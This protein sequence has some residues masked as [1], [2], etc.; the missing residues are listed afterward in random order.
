MKNFAVVDLVEQDGAF[1]QQ[2]R[3]GL[4]ETKHKGQFFHTGIDKVID[5][6]ATAT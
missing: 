4:A 3:I 6:R 5:Q 2:A 1:L